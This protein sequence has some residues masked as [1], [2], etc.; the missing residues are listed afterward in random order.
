MPRSRRSIP[1]ISK[2][3][4]LISTT[5]DTVVENRKF[6]FSNLRI[7][8][9]HAFISCFISQK[10][11]DNLISKSTFC[12]LHFQFCFSN[13]AKPPDFSYHIHFSTPHATSQTG[14][15]RPSQIP[16][17]RNPARTNYHGTRTLRKYSH[18]YSPS[19]SSLHLCILHERTAR[20]IP[21]AQRPT[22]LASQAHSTSI[23]HRCAAL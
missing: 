12:L 14:T 22:A 8:K 4:T 20:E 2:L 17:R 3:E 9:P 7:P 10:F 5:T 19:H 1:R 13:S 16:R 15:N 18:C 6:F 23:R 21:L 11:S